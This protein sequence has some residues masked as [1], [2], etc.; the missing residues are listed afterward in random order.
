MLTKRETLVMRPILQGD[1][2]LAND[3]TH[4]LLTML[5]TRCGRIC[6]EDTPERVRPES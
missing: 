4:I 5:L 2:D 6:S 1:E 3:Y